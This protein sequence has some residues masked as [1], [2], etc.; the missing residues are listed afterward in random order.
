RARRRQP[1]TTDRRKLYAAALLNAGRRDNLGK[2]REALTEITS[3]N[4]P[5]ARALYLLSQA[6]RRLG[7]FKEA[8]A[9]ARRVI[10]QNNK[11]PWGYYALAESLEMRHQYQAVVDELAPVVASFR[12]KSERSFDAG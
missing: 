2:P 1:S 3:S 11:S 9:S 8:E 10:A 6:Y 4:S 12:G 5:N 7:D